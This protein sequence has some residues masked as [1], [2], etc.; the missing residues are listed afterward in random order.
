MQFL[1]LAPPIKKTHQKFKNIIIYFNT[2]FIA[3][4]DTWFSYAGKN[5]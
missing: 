3:L 1:N 4:F 2:W 5:K